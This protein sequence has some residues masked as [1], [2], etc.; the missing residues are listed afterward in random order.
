MDNHT[1]TGGEPRRKLSDILNG[2]GDSLRS[3]WDATAAASDFAPLPAGIYTA[4]I[5]GGELSTAK[6][7]T[8]GYKLTFRVLEGE[9]AGRQ[10]W[11]D[12]WLTAAAL[13]MAKRDL[14][15]IGVTALEQLEKPLPPGM[16]CHVKL[17]LR[18]NDD[19]TE[20]NRVRT[21]E[22]V[23]VDTL[24]DDAFAPAPTAE[25]ATLLPLLPP[26]PTRTP[27]SEGR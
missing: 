22:V 18:K 12:L 15:K 6:A 1:T 7:G 21:F 25:P 10:V 3:A 24:D 23:G 11:H 5:I 9:H 14:A 19:G 26:E 2:S 4:R 13:P 20:F 16:R 27:Q 8:P 17:A